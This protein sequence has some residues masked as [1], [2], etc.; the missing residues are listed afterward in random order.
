M[1]SK[2]RSAIVSAAYSFNDHGPIDGS[3]R[4]IGEESTLLV[5]KGKLTDIER[6]EVPL[7]G[8]S[9]VNEDQ[10]F[11]SAIRERRKPL[12]SCAACLPTMEIL[13]PPN[14]QWTV[15]GER[16]SDGWRARSTTTSSSWAA[17]RAGSSRR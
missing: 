10:E 2:S 8:D 15:G 13:G 12:T 11:F 14:G 3:T 7:E 5:A 16:R 6:G 17:A 9:V 1:R 4:F